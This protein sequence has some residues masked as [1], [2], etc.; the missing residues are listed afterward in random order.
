MVWGEVSDEHLRMTHYAPDSSAAAVI[1]GDYGYA[2]FEDDGDLIFE[3]HTRIKILTEGG[4]GWGDVT[5]PYYA[6]DKTQRVR[7]VDAQTYHLGPDGR[8]V[9]TAL[10]RRDV[11]DEDVDGQWK[12]LRFT[13]PALQPGAVIE[14]RYRIISAHARYLPSWTFQWGEPVLWSEYR[15]DIPE[16]YRFVSHY[17]GA[18]QPGIVE[19]EPRYR[20]MHWAMRVP[21]PSGARRMEMA[22]V[23]SEL[24]ETAHR[25]VMQAAPALREEPFMTTPED[26]RARLHFQLAE[27]RPPAAPTVHVE[28]KGERFDLPAGNMPS[29]PVMTSWE[30][31]A[32]ELLASSR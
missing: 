10:G 1:L 25:W 22:R 31:L 12:Q 20:Q 16:I 30:Q 21:D 7:D 6:E 23:S 9:T 5:I 2:Y 26:Y 19:E 29:T 18:L 14:Y 11:F 13:L 32:D 4:Y 15:A 17:Q 24:R 27:I 8:T 28:F 3:R